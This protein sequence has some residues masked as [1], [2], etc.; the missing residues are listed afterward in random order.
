MTRWEQSERKTLWE[1]LR[2]TGSKSSAARWLGIPRSRLYSLVNR[3]GLPAPSPRR[4]GL[5][6]A[7]AH[8]GIRWRGSVRKLSPEK[9]AELLHLA[10]VGFRVRARLT[11]PDLGGS[12]AEF[13]D[14]SKAW[15]LVRRSLA[16][17]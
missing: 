1:A 5:P 12:A 6:A 11:H 8:L 13:V 16:A 9:R 15:G 4:W 2:R 3:Y 14:L 10:K 17:S 7:L